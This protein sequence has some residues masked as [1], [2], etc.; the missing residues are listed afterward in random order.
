M[1]I[2]YDQNARRFYI[3]L[4]GEEAE[5]TYREGEDGILIYHHTYV[6]PGLRGGG[7]A[8]KI[9]RFALAWAREEGRVVK[10]T[11]PYIVAFLEKH[12]EFGDI[13]VS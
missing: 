10:P 9:T 11:C 5:L 6:P 12:P 4:N 7:V 1:K 8:G 2:N 3:S 13:I